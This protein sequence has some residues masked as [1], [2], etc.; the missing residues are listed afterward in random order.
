MSAFVPAES[1]TT[2]ACSCTPT[3]KAIEIALKRLQSKGFSGTGAAL[4]L[5]SV[6]FCR[7]VVEATHVYAE[8]ETSLPY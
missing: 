5:S 8:N 1:S 7:K 4:L 2:A 3:G 6:V